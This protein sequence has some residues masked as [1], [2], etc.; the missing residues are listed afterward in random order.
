MLSI[1]CYKLFISYQNVLYKLL[2]R[3]V[4]PTRCEYALYTLKI[5]N[6]TSVVQHVPAF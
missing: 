6:E 2:T 5:E 1:H 4:R 3:Y